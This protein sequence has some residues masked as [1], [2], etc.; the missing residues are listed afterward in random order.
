MVGGCT[1]NLVSMDQ[2]NNEQMLD[3]V[4]ME[5]LQQTHG[6]SKNDGPLL[7]HTH[8]VL[9]RYKNVYTNELRQKLLR[10]NRIDH[11]IKVI[12]GFQPHSKA[13]YRLN[14]KQLLELKKQLNDLLSRYYKS[15]TSL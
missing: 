15:H 12:L 13:L 4:Q 3:V 7:N 1:L 5:Q 8:E 9:A 10:N 14:Q 2:I 6:E 11:K